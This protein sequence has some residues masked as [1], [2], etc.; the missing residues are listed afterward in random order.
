[1]AVVKLPF[2]IRRLSLLVRGALV[3]RDNPNFANLESI[4]D[5]ERFVWAIL[6]HAAR[7]FGPSILLLPKHEAK[8]SAV[9][10]LY[11][12]MLDTYEDLSASPPAAREA[13]AGFADRF[14]TKRPSTA[15]TAPHPPNT[16]AR[17]RTH[18]LLVDRHA[19]VDEVFLELDATTR[20]RVVE[21]VE[22][23]AQGMS[24]FSAVFERQGGVLEDDQQVLDYCRQVIGLPALF[25]MDLILD[26][27]S[28][29]QARDAM[30]V[31][32]L[33]QL[34]NITRDVEKDLRLGVA[35]HPSLRPHLGSAGDGRAAEAIA[36]ARH[37]MMRLA[38]QRAPS[39]RRLVTGVRLP[40]LS[41]ARA[42]AVLMMLLTD[43]HYRGYAHGTASSSP[44][45]SRRFVAMVVQSLPA[46][47]SSRWADRVLLRV[48]RGLLA[49]V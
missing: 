6:P 13:L 8:A 40:R 9:A 43:R 18:L 41:G 14:K 28:D 1:L 37:D 4:T 49:T 15:P 48:E 46:A 36:S 32:E 11:A 27:M 45:A 38:I 19:L 47:F 44:S 23:M 7:S 21:L 20:A 26:D 16:D 35:Y 24:A 2:W 25:V 30:E 3:D 29:A 17:D 5:P 31:S 12:R 10:Y 39:F 22:E 33:I 42:A 34:A